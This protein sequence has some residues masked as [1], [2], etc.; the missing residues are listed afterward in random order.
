MHRKEGLSRLES[1]LSLKFSYERIGKGIGP[2]L[3]TNHFLTNFKETFSGKL[4][5]VLSELLELILAQD[6]VNCAVYLG[7]S[8]LLLMPFLLFSTTAEKLEALF[9]FQKS[10]S[11]DA[12]KLLRNRRVRS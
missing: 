9:A 2:G 5:I 1:I 7:V 11:D 10:I 12:L 4:R 3:D 6:L 8:H